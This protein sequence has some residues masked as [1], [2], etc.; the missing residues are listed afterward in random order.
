MYIFN[1]RSES[2]NIWEEFYRVWLWIILM[3]VT[4][5]VKCSYQEAE[6]KV[7]G[8]IRTIRS[9][10]INLENTGKFVGHFWFEIY[11][12]IN[13]VIYVLAYSDQWIPGIVVYRYFCWFE[14]DFKF[15]TWRVEGNHNIMNVDAKSWFPIEQELWLSVH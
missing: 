5:V 8:V 15:S 13:L 3:I 4:R 14:R 9:V 10:C 7:Y 2:G 11:W 1:A 12:C 6:E